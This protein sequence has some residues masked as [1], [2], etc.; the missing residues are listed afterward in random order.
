M[1]FWK[2]E[3]GM[4]V[5]PDQIVWLWLWLIQAFMCRNYATKFVPGN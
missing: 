5:V 2:L 1:D 4:S 3:L